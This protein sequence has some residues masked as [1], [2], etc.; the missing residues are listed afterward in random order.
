MSKINIS[1]EEKIAAVKSFLNGEGSHEPIIDNET[2]DIVQD[3]ARR[4]VNF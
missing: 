1:S 3:K 2:W 4:K